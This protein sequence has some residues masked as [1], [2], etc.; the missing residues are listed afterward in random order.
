M[1]LSDK[2]DED[3]MRKKRNEGALAFT[4]LG[5]LFI[6]IGIVR[7]QWKPEWDISLGMAMI[8]AAMLLLAFLLKR[9]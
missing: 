5:I 6:A 8:G 3:Y 9:I 2:P 7:Y 1:R 4:F